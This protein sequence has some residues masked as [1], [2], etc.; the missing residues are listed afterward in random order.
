MTGESIQMKK[1]SVQ[2]KRKVWW[3][4]IGVKI[5][6]AAVILVRKIDLILR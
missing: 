3:R 6:L 5:V 2:V 1:K 4:S